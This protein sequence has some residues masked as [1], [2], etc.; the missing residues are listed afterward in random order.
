M[1]SEHSFLRFRK[2]DCELYR[3]AEKVV[4]SRLLKK[5]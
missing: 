2:S 3:A 5:G 1:S 4:L